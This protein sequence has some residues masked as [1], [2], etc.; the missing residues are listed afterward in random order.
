VGALC[1]VVAQ[2][3]GCDRQGELGDDFPVFGIWYLVFL[4]HPRFALCKACCVY[5]FGLSGG[6]LLAAH[7]NGFLLLLF[8]SFS[9]QVEWL[10]ENDDM[11]R[12]IAKNAQ[13]FA[14][15]YLRLEDY[16]CYAA[17]T[18]RLLHDLEKTTDVLEGFSP[19]KIGRGRR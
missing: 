4:S 9:V 2:H 10:K 12:Q 15:S 14:L 8:D 19:V 18:L 3:G 1:A 6:A 13:N 16:L 5:W 11:A 7:T 17:G